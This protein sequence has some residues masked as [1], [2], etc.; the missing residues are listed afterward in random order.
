MNEQNSL[1]EGYSNEEKGAYLA[2]I[3]TIATADHMAD[4]QEISYLENLCE[5]ANL[6]EDQVQQVTVSARDTTGEGLTRHLDTL[7]NSELKYSLVT[8]MIAFARSDGSYHQAEKEQIEKVAQHLGVNQQQFALLD[9]FTEKAAASGAPPEEKMS[10]DFL[11][12]LG[13][14]DKMQ[15]AGINTNS[16]FKGLIAI[17]GPMILSKVLGG[18]FGRRGKSGAGMGGGL[19]P[20]G[21]GMGGGGLLGGLGSLIGMM[22]GGRGFGKSGGLLGKLGL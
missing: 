8:D 12:S 7:K 6:P 13:I 16:L 17:A 4:E 20:G 2:T 14:Q 15:A 10:P 21:G 11:G 5:A 22:S 18:I 19:F 1:L 3:A 9:Q